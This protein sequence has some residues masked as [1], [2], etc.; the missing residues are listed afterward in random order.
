MKMTFL[1]LFLICTCKDPNLA[2]KLTHF[3]E[4]LIKKLNF[5]EFMEFV[6]S[7]PALELAGREAASKFCLQMA[8]E[9]ASQSFWIGDNYPWVTCGPW[10][11]ERI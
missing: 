4:N 8:L 1:K 11:Y 5:T 2:E 7:R 9:H 3:A 6:F 10:Q